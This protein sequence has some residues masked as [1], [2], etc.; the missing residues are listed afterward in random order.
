MIDHVVYLTAIL[1]PEFSL[2]K[3]S[4]MYFPLF[5]LTSFTY[6][7]GM[8]WNLLN[9]KICPFILREDVNH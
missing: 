3:A 8:Q 1:L 4:L 9:F 5:I 7:S 6:I 2:G